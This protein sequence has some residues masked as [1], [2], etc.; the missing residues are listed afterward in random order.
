[1][2]MVRAIMFSNFS[3]VLEIQSARRM[4]FDVWSAIATEPSEQTQTMRK[5]KPHRNTSFPSLPPTNPKDAIGFLPFFLTR[6]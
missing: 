6:Q 5:S 2:S 3:G 1:M 4:V